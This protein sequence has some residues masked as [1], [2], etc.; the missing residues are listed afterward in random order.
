MLGASWLNT[1]LYALRANMVRSEAE[2]ETSSHLR[3]C[4]RN[5]S[6]RSP[7][8]SPNNHPRPTS[9]PRIPDFLGITRLVYTGNS[10]SLVSRCRHILQPMS[11]PQPLCRSL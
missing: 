4:K 1:R 2:Q 3:A 8:F 6:P 7:F 11:K 9:K 10:E 5:V